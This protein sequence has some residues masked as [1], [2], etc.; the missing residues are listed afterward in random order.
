MTVKFFSLTII[1]FAT[2]VCASSSSLTEEKVENV[3]GPSIT[4]GN[5]TSTPANELVYTDHIEKRFI[6]FYERSET[7][8]YYGDKIIYCIKVKNLR[9]S[10]VGHAKIIG[11]GVEHPFARIY[12]ESAR[13]HGM[14]FKIY[15]YA[16]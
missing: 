14:D 4:D 1:V 2:I 9:T 15:I 7:S 16:K 13:S 8:I 3:Y 10:N 6:P 12:T 11:G 5:C